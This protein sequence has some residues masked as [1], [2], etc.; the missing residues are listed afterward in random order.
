MVL[1]AVPLQQFSLEFV[2]ELVASFSCL[3]L[4]FVEGLLV[5]RFFLDAGIDIQIVLRHVRADIFA[6]EDDLTI[7]HHGGDLLTTFVPMRHH[8]GVSFD[9]SDES[10]VHF[11]PVFVVHCLSFYGSDTSDNSTADEHSVTTK[12]A[13]GFAGGH[14]L[15]RIDGKTDD[16][17]EENE[18]T[19]DD[20]HHF[21]F[22]IELNQDATSAASCLE[23]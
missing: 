15:G 13:N 9:T 19:G 14:G 10:S 20:E 21:S 17:A 11:N 2:P 4:G 1:D 3:S 6:E 12:E 18:N 5:E 7:R 8:V 16:H 23:A 22:F